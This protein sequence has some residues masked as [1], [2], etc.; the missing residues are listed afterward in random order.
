[1]IKPKL[2]FVESL[3]TRPCNL[4]CTGC[5]TFSDL[6]HKGY[7]RWENEKDFIEAWANRLDIQAWGVMGGEPLMNPYL[8]DWVTG[9]REL[10]PDAQIRIVTNG[11]LLERHWDLVELLSEIGNCIL[12]IT[13]HIDD[14]RIN[15]V[16]NKIKASWNWQPVYEFGIHRWKIDNDFKFQITHPDVY[17]KTFVGEY[18]NMRPHNN[19]PVNAFSVC[20]QQ[21]CPMIYKGKLYKCGTA[22]LTQEILERFNKPN[23]DKWEPYLNKGLDIN[24]SDL[25]LQQFSDN[26][27]KP[28][29]ICRQCPTNKDIGSIIPHKINVKFK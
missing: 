12:K 8:K 4:A 13:V 11:I 29:Q 27:G 19:D 5:S 22:A 15:N 6:E 14:D 25:E 2:E 10:L 9:I 7:S 20:S 17:Y 24:C 1:M 21:R 18:E 23:W 3:V 28:H 26:F 16:I